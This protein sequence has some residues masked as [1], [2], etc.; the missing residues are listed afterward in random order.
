MSTLQYTIVG[1]DG[2]QTIVVVVDGKMHTA[3][4]SHPS[5]PEIVLRAVAGDESV[6]DLF[7]VAQTIADAV[8]DE[9][10]SER[11]RAEHGRITF[12]GDPLDE[13]L[14]NTILRY[15]RDGDR[16]RLEPLVLFVEKVMTNT[17]EHS[18]DQAFGW[19]S[20]QSF[21]LTDDGN[22]LAYKGVYNQG[23]GSYRATWGGD[24]IVNGVRSD[25]PSFSIGDTVELPRS[26]VVHNPAAS[27][28][29][30]L[31]IGTKS[32]ARSYGNAQ[33]LVEVN[34]RDFVSVPNGE[35]EKARV[36][37]YKVV[38]DVTDETEAR[39]ISASAPGA[40][41]CRYCGKTQLTGCEYPVV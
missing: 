5:F 2:M 30:G 24:A 8:A 6:V 13:S 22:V 35:G 32:Y 39:P 23:D 7:D 27:C 25:N 28:A 20:N 12:D 41:V 3:A 18:R 16:D 11:L 21:S 17:V 34:P 37:R 33:I 26:E 1:Y 9:Q 40:Q 4:D 38:A 15:M 19:L 29:R 31:H 36:N 10:L 14:E